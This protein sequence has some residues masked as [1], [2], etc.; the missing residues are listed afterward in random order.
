MRNP[1]VTLYDSNRLAALSQTER[2]R[3]PL[4]NCQQK[5]DFPEHQQQ[6]L[7]QNVSWLLTPY[8]L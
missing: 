7:R 2:S 6:D 4:P 8:K 5:P 3:Q 1:T